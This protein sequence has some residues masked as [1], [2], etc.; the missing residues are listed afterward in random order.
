MS[1]TLYGMSDNCSKERGG[2]YFLRGR[3]GG[4]TTYAHQWVRPVCRVRFVAR[5]L[6]GRP[7]S[8]EPGR[9]RQ[10]RKMRGIRSFS[11]IRTSLSSDMC[12]GRRTDEY[13]WTLDLAKDVQDHEQR[14]DI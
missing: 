4:G 13:S 14:N 2:Q 10:C 6:R 5:V 9:V 8:V 1:S 7:C 12:G 3:I 11:E